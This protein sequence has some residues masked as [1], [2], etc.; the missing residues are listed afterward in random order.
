MDKDDILDYSPKKG[1]IIFKQPECYICLLNKIE[2][3]FNNAI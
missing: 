3:S 2:F 1:W